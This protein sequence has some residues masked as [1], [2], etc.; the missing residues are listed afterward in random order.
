MSFKIVFLQQ[1]F[2]CSNSDLLLSAEIIKFLSE[3][4]VI[5]C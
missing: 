3:V 5:S 4:S 1:G 2:S